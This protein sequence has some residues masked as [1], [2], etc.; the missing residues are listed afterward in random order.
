MQYQYDH[1]RPALTVDDVILSSPSERPTRVLLIQR[2][3]PPFEGAWAFPGGFVDIDET[4]E[5]AVIRELKEETGIT[6]INFEQLHTFT[7]V[8]RDPRERV[9][10][11][12]FIGE[13]EP[14]IHHPMA[15]DDASDSKWFPID[16]LPPL[17]F[18][19]S[20]VIMVALKRRGY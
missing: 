5:A 12:A 7:S 16:S 20:E 11:I 18:D 1:P 2:K 13:G 17:A 19:H 14:S 9:V 4:A 15:A 6:G 10:S 3:S 8:D